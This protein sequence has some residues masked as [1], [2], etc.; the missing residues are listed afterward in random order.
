MWRLHGR[1][2]Q[3]RRA[4]KVLIRGFDYNCTNY[5]FTKGKHGLLKKETRNRLPEG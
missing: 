2:A 4:Y 3:R 5:N 1:Q